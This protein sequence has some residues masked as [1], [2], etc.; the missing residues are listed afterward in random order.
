[1][2]DRILLTYCPNNPGR[3]GSDLFERLRVHPNIELNAPYCRSM[4]ETCEA[5]FYA[6]VGEGTLA[7]KLAFGETE[8]EFLESLERQTGLDLSQY[9]ADK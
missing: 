9:K 3:H 7:D 1:M 5:T 4:C 6:F 8:I 2:S